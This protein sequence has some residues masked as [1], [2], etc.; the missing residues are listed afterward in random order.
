MIQPHLRAQIKE[1]MQS[2]KETGKVF[3]KRL[4]QIPSLSGHEQSIMEWI[5]TEVQN[6]RAN[7]AFFFPYGVNVRDCGGRSVRCK[8]ASNSASVS[9]QRLRIFHEAS[10]GVWISSMLRGCAAPSNSCRRT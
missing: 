10:P 4:I 8:N 2:Q 7:L 1:Y 9:I 5:E 3:L 6:M